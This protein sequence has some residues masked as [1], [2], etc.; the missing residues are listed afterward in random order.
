M[1]DSCHHGNEPSVSEKRGNFLTVSFSIGTSTDEVRQL[2]FIFVH[3]C[4][5]PLGRVRGDEKGTNLMT[6]RRWR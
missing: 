1:A 2:F 6:G 3:S 5:H 4:Q